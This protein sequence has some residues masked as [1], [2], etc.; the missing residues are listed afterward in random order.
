L[1]IKL[2]KKKF[3]DNLVDK[4]QSI[5]KNSPLKEVKNNLRSVIQSKLDEFNLVS[6]EEFEVQ[7]EVLRKTRE[8]LEDLEKKIENKIK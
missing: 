6:R 5:T 2:D 7:K 1:E 4:I 3:I 8:K